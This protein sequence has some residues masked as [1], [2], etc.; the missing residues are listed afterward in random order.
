MN[1]CIDRCPFFAN[2]QCEG[3]CSQHALERCSQLVD[4]LPLPTE[5][6]DQIWKLCGQ[7]E[8]RNLTDEEIAERLGM[9]P[10]DIF[11]DTETVRERV[12]WL[13]HHHH[14]YVGMG[15]NEMLG[16]PPNKKLRKEDAELLMNTMDERIHRGEFY[17]RLTTEKA[18]VCHTFH[19][20]G[21]TRELFPVGLCYHGT[22]A[23]TTKMTIQQIHNIIS[24]EAMAGGGGGGGGG[25][26]H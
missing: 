10:V 12:H 2:E 8:H 21:L 17:C 24:G 5:L 26:G 22:P 4:Q 14:G 9:D 15:A 11:I 18:I 16:L 13:R 23:C 20:G 3:R 6:T 1:C 25:G 19:R 7:R